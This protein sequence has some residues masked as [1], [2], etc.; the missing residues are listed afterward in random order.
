M[1]LKTTKIPFLALALFL[2]FSAFCQTFTDVS[3]SSG[4]DM[5]HDGVPFATDMP[6]AGGAAW[7]DYNND[8][9]LDLYVTN[10]FTANKLYRNNGNGTF[11]DVASA[12]G[13]DDASGDGAGVVVGDINNDGF[14]DIFLANGDEDKLYRNNNGTSFTDI[15]ASSGLLA[16]FDSRG[17]SGSFGDYDKDGYLDLFIAHHMPI[18]GSS[19]DATNQDFLFL[20]NG[21]ETFTDVSNILGINNLMDAAFIGGWTDIDHDQDLDLILINDCPF[22]FYSNSG[23]RLFRNDGGTD[24]VSDWTFT[25]MSSSLFSDCSNGMGIGIGDFNHDGW[26]DIVYTDIGPIQLFASQS[27]TFTDISNSAGVGT[28]STSHYSWGTSFFDY[29]NDMWQDIIVSLGAFWPDV[30]NGHHNNLFENNGDGT[31]T[32]VAAAMGLNSELKTRTCVHGDYDN[33]GDLDLFMMNYDTT[34]Y[35]FRNDVANSNNYLR[36]FL[37]G[38]NGN[39]DGLGAKLKIETPDGETQHFEMKSGTNLGGGDEM[40][41]HFGLGTNATVSELEVTWLSGAISTQYNIPANS[42][43]GVAEPL[44]LPV[45]LS[46]FYAKKIGLETAI[47]WTT[48]SETNN[49]FFEIQ[50]SSDGV[51]FKKIGRIKGHGNSVQNRSYSFMDKHPEKGINYYRI[52]QVDYDGAS[53]LSKTASVFFETEKIVADVYPNPVNNNT[54]TL[55]F[56]K[57]MDGEL[58]VEL[59]DL[60]GKL[61]YQ[62]YIEEVYFDSPT[63]TLDLQNV[64]NGIYFLKIG[65]HQGIQTTKLIVNK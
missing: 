4:V 31:F 10:R 43:S 49:E 42:I 58:T 2:S 12:M 60:S 38:T 3:V 5:D 19:Q 46:S 45:E 35:L 17:T 24:P 61:I 55:T 21:N 23:T 54:V 50:R 20:N 8:G 37:T 6:I 30:N 14:C 41:A 65:T 34:C 53:S 9:F 44:M 15:T 11:T 7:F 26:M 62:N 18:P 48:A 32:D 36:V 29:N 64:T 51:N 47:N 1:T 57:D 40:A 16:T 28:Q 33:D 22:S 59:F 13:V 25:E 52:K 27:G 39:R 63:Q 56:P